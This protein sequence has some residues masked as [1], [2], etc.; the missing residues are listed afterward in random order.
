MAATR[1]PKKTSHQD[2][3]EASRHGERVASV[4]VREQA[5][6]DAANPTVQEWERLML[7]YQR[8]LSWAKP[9]EK[10]VL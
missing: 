3:E 7:T 10:W 2:R 9:G 8:A 4:F 1:R 6:A 5:A